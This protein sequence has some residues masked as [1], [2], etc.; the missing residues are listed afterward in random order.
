MVV[1]FSMN[2]YIFYDE[3]LENGVVVYN[4]FKKI[5]E[6]KKYNLEME[7]FLN[8]SFLEKDKLYVSDRNIKSLKQYC[9]NGQE[10]FEYK[11]KY[12]RLLFRIFFVCNNDNVLFFG[13]LDKEDKK[14]YNKI[15]KKRI[16]KKYAD[17]IFFT[18][19]YYQEYGKTLNK[20]IKFKIYE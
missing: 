5:K 20:F 14:E 2:I 10:I 11:K 4:F 9:Y 18:K 17:Q 8:H 1:I 19:K 13:F 12:S 6:N 16:R 7:A 15:E 3:K